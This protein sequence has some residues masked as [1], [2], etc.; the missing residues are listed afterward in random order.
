[1]RKYQVQ[2]AYALNPFQQYKASKHEDVPKDKLGKMEHT[3][4]T[5]SYIFIRRVIIKSLQGTK[6]TKK[7]FSNFGDITERG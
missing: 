1:M 5:I 7:G 6:Q 3:Y 2:I 4:N